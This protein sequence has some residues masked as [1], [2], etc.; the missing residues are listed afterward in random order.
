MK[1]I[2]IFASGSGTNAENFARF[3][4]H[5]DTVRISLVLS[6]HATAGVHQ[7]MTAFG[8][9][10]MTFSNECFR[11]G[12][13]IVKVL[14]ENNIDFIVLAGFM[15]KIS[16]PLLEAYPNKIVNIHPALLPKFGGKGM[17]GMHVH[18]A[19]I[20]AKEKESGIT[21]HYI[22][23]HY[24]EGTIIFQSKCPIIPE[25]DAESVATK[26][27]ALEYEFYPKVVKDLLSR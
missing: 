16:D 1:N 11:N 26:V 14:K 25:D 18:E 7:R 10:T 19:V 4:A 15:N 23:E 8:I 21:I 5:D 3:F 12:D 20:A 27:H 22:D 2:A 9:P 17:Y 6:N 24:D 13:D